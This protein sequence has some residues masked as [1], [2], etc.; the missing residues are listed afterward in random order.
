MLKQL[1]LMWRKDSYKKFDKLRVFWNIEERDG[2]VG[3]SELAKAVGE[4]T[5]ALHS[6]KNYCL[7]NGI[8][9]QVIQHRY[10]ITEFGKELLE[11]END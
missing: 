2:S 5:T 9:K 10:G 11:S 7:E 1:I 4:T 6:W 3:I 8:I